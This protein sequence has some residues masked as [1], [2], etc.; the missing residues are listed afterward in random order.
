MGNKI[1]K[2]CSPTLA[3]L[4]VGNLFAYEYNNIVTLYQVVMAISRLI[5]KKGV[6]IH[7]LQLKNN[8][9]LIYIYRKKQLQ[10]LLKNKEIRSFL[11]EC[12]Y[13]NFNVYDALQ[14]LSKHLK[15]QDFPHEI[16]VFLDYPLD[17]VK[18]FIAHKGL[19]YKAVGCWKVYHNLDNALN[20]FERFEKCTKRFIQRYQQGF[21][22]EYLTVRC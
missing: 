17:D 7:I 21:D 11:H 22:I 19:N 20:L 16:G 1:I 3:G 13:Q 6:Y 12:D 5:N 9:A 14:Q 10:E 18:S 2:Y 15:K 4:K 8:R